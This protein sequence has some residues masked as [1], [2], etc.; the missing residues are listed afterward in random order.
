MSIVT[1]N[2]AGKDVCGSPVNISTPSRIARSGWAFALHGRGAALIAGGVVLFFTLLTRLIF[3]CTTPVVADEA[4]YYVWTRH[5]AGGYIDG[6]PLVAYVNACC[7]ALFGANAFGVRIGAVVLVTLVSLYLFLWGRRRFGTVTGLL[8]LCF[9]CLTPAIF[10]SS[11]VHTYDTEMAVFMQAAIALYYDAFFID[12]RY[13]YPAGALLGLALLAKVTVLF[14]AL[15]ILCA[16]LLVR[17]LRSVLRKR[18]FYLSFLIALLIFSPFIY[19]DATHNFAFM[20]YKGGMAFRPGDWHDFLGVWAE[21][22]SL[23][24]PILC[25]FAIMLPFRAV[26][27]YLRRAAMPPEELFFALIGVFPLL[28]FGIGSFFSRYYGNWV[29]P[30]FF[31]GLL[32]AAVHFGRQWPRYR[33]L[34]LWQA[35]R[36]GRHARADPRPALRECAA[37]ASAK[38]SHLRLLLLFSH[39]R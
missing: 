24:V 13:F 5:M 12:R 30:A 37:A 6:G 17:E 18:E 33:G 2:A 38:R 4:Y 21:Q 15:A 27:R 20:R 22:F 7:V 32:L 9:T 8:L 35:H 10:I 36:F 28:Y 16:P 3:I 26:A 34:V 29:A 19:W 25:W 39:P 14:P 11:V 31:G 1:D 23:F